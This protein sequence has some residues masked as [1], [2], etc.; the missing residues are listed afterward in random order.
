MSLSLIVSIHTLESILFV[1]SERV[2][3]TALEIDC[4]LFWTTPPL[5]VVEPPEV[6]SPA[7]GDG[8]GNG[9]AGTGGEG[10]IAFLTFI[11]G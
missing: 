5:T 4:G 2:C 11:S 1:I 3:Y 7:A 6:A 10:A 8:D 9:T